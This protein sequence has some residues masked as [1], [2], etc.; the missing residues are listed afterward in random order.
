MA[1]SFRVEFLKAGRAV[2][3]PAGVSILK[4]AV[5]SDIDLEFLCT[6]GTCGTCKAKLVKGEIEYL[7][8][9]DI[10]FED[11]KADGIILLCQ[12]TPKSDIVIEEI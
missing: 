12:A 7:I 9:P 5:D 1:Q 6:S 8:E 2:E 3:V 4:I 11:E 10:I